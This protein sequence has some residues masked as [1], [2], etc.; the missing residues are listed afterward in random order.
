MSVLNLFA[1]ARGVHPPVATAGGPATEVDRDSLAAIIQADLAPKVRE[2]DGGV[3]P[4]DVMR[5]LGP[6]GLYGA[7]VGAPDDACDLTATIESMAKVGET[8]LSTAFCVWC[9]DALAWYIYSS[10]N[11]YLKTEIG[12]KVVAGEALGGTGLSNP[13]KAIN[14][15]EPMR[16]KGRRVA[17]GYL[18]KGVLPWVSNLGEQGY[19][20]IVFDIE[21]DGESRRAMAIAHAGWDNLKLKLDHDFVAMGGTCHLSGAVPRRV[22]AR[23]VSARRSGGRLHQADPRRLRS[24]AMRHGRRP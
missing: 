8:C 5:K 2:I 12:P 23:R 1:S 13:M 3:Y 21:E 22:F 7:H 20:G 17:G 24:A 19:F 14:G 10:D 11:E 9:Q 4:E 16:L 15:I 18:I 6:A